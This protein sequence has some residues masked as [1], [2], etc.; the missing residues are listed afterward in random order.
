M[1][2]TNERNVQIVISL[3]K[4]H[5]IRRVIAS[6]GTTN[7][8]QSQEF[9]DTVITTE[10]LKRIDAG[11]TLDECIEEAVMK[12]PQYEDAIRLNDIFIFNIQLILYNLPYI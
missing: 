3:L 2:Y 8:T 4:A 5:G 1:F 12:H 9:I 7:M 6:P 10:W 11:H